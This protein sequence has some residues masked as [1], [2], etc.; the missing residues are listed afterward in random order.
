MSEDEILVRCDDD[1]AD[2]WEQRALREVEVE[3]MPDADQVEAEMY[4][5]KA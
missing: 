2:W 4:G 3:A 5:V 1:Y